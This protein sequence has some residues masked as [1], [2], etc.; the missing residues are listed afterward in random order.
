MA[1]HRHTQRA[2]PAVEALRRILDAQLHGSAAFSDESYQ[3]EAIIFSG[4]KLKSFV[5]EPLAEARALE[6]SPE[7]AHH[8]TSYRF[9]R[10][11]QLLATY[12]DDFEFKGHFSEYYPS[13]Q[14]MNNEELR[15]YFAWRTQWRA[16]IVRPTEKSFIYVLAYELLHCVGTAGPEQAYEQLA[17]LREDYGHHPLDRRLVKNLTEWMDAFVIYWGLPSQ[18]IEKLAREKEDRALAALMRMSQGSNNAARNEMPRNVE[19]GNNVSN[20]DARSSGNEAISNASNNEAISNEELFSAL[21]NFAGTSL[22][23]S[24]AYKTEPQLVQYVVCE[25]LRLINEHHKTSLKTGFIESYCGKRRERTIY[26]LDNALFAYPLGNTERIY[27]L[28]PYDRIVCRGITWSRQ[29]FWGMPR[30]KAKFAKLF[31]TIDAVLR[32][33]LQLE[34]LKFY[35]ITTHYILDAA[36][37]LTQQ[38]LSARKEA[39][40]REVHIDLSQLSGIRAAADITRDRLLVEE[41][42]ELEL[43]APPKTAPSAVA[44]AASTPPVHVSKQKV[45]ASEALSAQKASASK[46]A[47]AQTV[48]A[49][50][51]VSPQKAPAPASA[52]TQAIDT[53]ALSADERALLEQLLAHKSVRDFEREH[54][55]MASLLIDA[56]NDKLFDLIGD[57]AIDASSDKPYIYEDYID[58]IRELFHGLGT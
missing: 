42:A 35:L 11:A 57:V 36:R 47:S 50:E 56:L 30:A 16:G 18:L 39:K 2:R 20:N 10:E 17:R 46:S 7:L 51:P 37:S 1:E 21:V 3:D 29:R 4:E 32:E 58:D 41:E 43:V 55:L 13:Y 44:A 19:L 5:P 33:E 54:H 49:S 27:E 24:P 45:S 31:Q 52:S 14:K 28:N 9:W 53:P 40:L 48:P 38:F 8:S 6:R 23:E 34:P 15:G 25:V 12:E 26:L 22:Q